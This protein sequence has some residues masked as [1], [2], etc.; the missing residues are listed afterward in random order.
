MAIFTLPVKQCSSETAVI[1]LHV[2]ILGTYSTS[3]TYR[4][5]HHGTFWGTI[6][7][8]SGGHRLTVTVT[9]F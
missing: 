5:V 6:A 4:W 2:L 1:K 3:P 9:V 7:I 8:N